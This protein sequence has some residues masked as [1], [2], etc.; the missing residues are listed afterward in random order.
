MHK[1]ENPYS[2]PEADQTDMLRKLALYWDGQWFLKIVEEF[3]IPAGIEINARV[4]ASFGRIE[5]RTLLKTLKKKKAAN[6]EDAIQLLQTYLDVFM[7]KRL[8][9]Q[10]SLVS[11]NEA[12]IVVSRCAAFEGAKRAK[13]ER[14]D[15]ACIACEGLWSVWLDVLLPDNAIDIQI[16]MQQGKGAPQCQF[17]IHTDNK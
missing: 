8:R 12:T 6:L 13:L 7:G 5:M 3:G 11:E 2:I 10:F 16:A 15:Q 17:D 1:I 9:A 14:S 4:R